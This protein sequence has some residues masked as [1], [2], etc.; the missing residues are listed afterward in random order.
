MKHQVIVIEK[1]SEISWD[2]IHKI[3]LAAHSDKNKDG[4]AQ[5]TAYL[6]GD[7]LKEKVGDGKCFVALMDGKLVGTASV[8]IREQNFW[9]HKGKI[10]YY[11]FGAILP[12]YQGFGIYS[13]LDAARDEYVKNS[14]IDAIYTHTS[15]RNKKMQEIK[16]KQ[17]YRLVNF[18]AS[19]K[20]D[21]YS[22]T[23]AKWIGNWPFPAWYCLFRFYLKKIYIRV[24]V[25]R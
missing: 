24:R 20:T 6:T 22:V 16:R 12:E 13:K 17:G 23:L 15:F 10:A 7:E 4:G 25:R 2:V 14:G 1:P 11:G 21:Y 8:T 9:Y 18:F 19:T 5:V 3:L